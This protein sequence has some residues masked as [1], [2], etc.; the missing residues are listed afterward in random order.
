MVKALDLTPK[1]KVILD[2]T[3]HL[4]PITGTEIEN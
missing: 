2:Q 4:K 1:D 3:F